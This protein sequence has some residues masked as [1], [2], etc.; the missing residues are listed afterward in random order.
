MKWEWQVGRHAQLVDLNH[1]GKPDLI[2][3]INQ[4]SN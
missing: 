1:D 2:R 3:F 4:V